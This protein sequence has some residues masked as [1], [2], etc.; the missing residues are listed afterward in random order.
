MITCS[1][2]NPGAFPQNTTPNPEL[3]NH[4]SRG[5][6]LPNKENDAG[7]RPQT[8]CV[9]VLIMCDNVEDD[10]DDGDH[11]DDDDGDDADDD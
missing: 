5:G 7:K 11:D 9:C 2:G 6:C 10:D 4:W 1:W 3:Y 8:V